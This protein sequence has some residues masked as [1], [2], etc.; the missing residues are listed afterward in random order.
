M[1]L[2]S[3]KCMDANC[4]HAFQRPSGPTQCLKCGKTYVE[5]TNFQT[6]W[7]YDLATNQWRRKKT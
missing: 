7:E 5:W 3:F 4:G 6:D 1:E 2:E